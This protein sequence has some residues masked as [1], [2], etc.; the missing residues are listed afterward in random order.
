MQYLEYYKWKI[1]LKDGTELVQS[2]PGE[3]ETFPF[4]EANKRFSQIKTF[5]LIPRLENSHLKEIKVTIPED[6]RLIYFRRT[7]ANT[8]NQYPKFQI[9]LIGWQMTI[10]GKNYKFLIYVYPDGQIEADSKDEPTY[11]PEFV[12]GLIE[13]NKPPVK[14][15]GLSFGI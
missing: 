8:G 1:L 6:G 9:N 3:K 4:C 5:T 10:D 11:F 15:S 13:A 7:H 2:E 14:N 12:K